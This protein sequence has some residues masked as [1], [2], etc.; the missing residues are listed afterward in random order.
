VS[1]KVNS[2]RVPGG[3]HADGSVYNQWQSRIC[4]WH[5]QKLKAADPHSAMG[6]FTRLLH[7]WGFIHSFGPGKGS[8]DSAKPLTR[9]AYQAFCLHEGGR[10]SCQMSVNVV[11]F[12]SRL[13]CTY[14]PGWLIQPPR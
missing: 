10:T 2:Q 3:H 8:A 14:P 4:Y 7:R 1:H 9:A 5:I 6:G 11:A 12:E 13:R